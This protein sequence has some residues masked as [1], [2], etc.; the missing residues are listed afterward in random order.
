MILTG[1]ATTG[2]RLQ[3]AAAERQGRAAAGVT[4]AP[5]P[6]ACREPWPLLPRAQLVGHDQLSAVKRYEAYI[7]GPINQQKRTCWQFNE[8]LRAGLAGTAKP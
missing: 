3:Q 7:A 4:I 8:D 5:Q 1:C 6:D 2:E